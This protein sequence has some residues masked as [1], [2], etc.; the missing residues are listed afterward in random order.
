VLASLRGAAREA[1]AGRGSVAV[2]D[3]RTTHV[4]RPAA[5]QADVLEL[6]ASGLT[7][8]QIAEKLVLS[9]RTV[10]HHVSAIPTKLGVPTRREAAATCESRQ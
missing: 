7:N 6:L 10:D 2:R 8:A 9:V 5:R 4:G 3:A 1:E